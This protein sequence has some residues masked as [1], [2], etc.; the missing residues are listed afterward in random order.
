MSH[1]AIARLQ[2]QRGGDMS[3]QIRTAGVVH[4]GGNSESLPLEDG[5][6]SGPQADEFFRSIILRCFFNCFAVTGKEK[7]L[8]QFPPVHRAIYRF[9]INSDRP[10]E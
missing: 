5:F 7:A 3:H 4:E 2:S 6:S 10:A 8:S 9:Q 1:V